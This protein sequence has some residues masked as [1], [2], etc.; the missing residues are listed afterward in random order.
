MT[1]V[2]F[3]KKCLPLLLGLRATVRVERFSIQFLERSKEMKKIMFYLQVVLL[4]LVVA[5]CG[6]QAQY[7]VKIR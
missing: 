3:V 2:H 6:G 4:L 5:G 7:G 1:I